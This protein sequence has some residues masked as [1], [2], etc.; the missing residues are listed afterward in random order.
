MSRAHADLHKPGHCCY[1]TID[2][3]VLC[4]CVCAWVCVWSGDIMWS[5]CCSLSTETFCSFPEAVPKGMELFTIVLPSSWLNCAMIVL[6]SFCFFFVPGTVLSP[7]YISHTG[8]SFILI[9]VVFK[10]NYL[11]F[12]WRIIALKNFAVFCQTSTWISHRYTYI[13]SLLKLPPI[14]LPIPPF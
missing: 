14:S 7:A 3:G 1:P 2:E 11:F 10:N 9:Q 12:Y 5:I 4:V 8:I 6:I 13:L